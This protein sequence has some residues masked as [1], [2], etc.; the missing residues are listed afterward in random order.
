MKQPSWIIPLKY[1]IGL[2]N[3]YLINE[4]L[5]AFVD[6]AWQ[7]VGIQVFSL[8]CDLVGHLLAPYL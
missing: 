2:V 5:G 7:L 8:A 4:Y 3:E 1:T 6:L